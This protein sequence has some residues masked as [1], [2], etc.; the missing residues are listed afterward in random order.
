MKHL[1]AVVFG[2]STIVAGSSIASAA[3]YI[4]HVHGRSQQ[5]WKSDPNGARMVLAD[6]SGT[7]WIN[8]TLAFN[9]NARLTSTETDSTTNT[10]SVNY[11]IRTFC[12]TGTGNTC[13]V[14]CYSTG[15][16]R[17]D[18]AIDNIRNGVGGTAN[19]LSGLLYI[20]ASASASGG[21]D[22]A[23]IAT[24]KFTGWLAK[25]LGQQEAVDK[26][27]TRSAARTTFSYV[28]D[29]LGVNKWHVAG[30]GD[31]CKKLLGLF[32]ICG[33]SSIAGTDDGVLP[34]A[35]SGG[36]SAQTSRTSL[37]NL[38][39]AD[40]QDTSKNVAN[41]YPWHRTDTYYVNC[42][43]TSV[44]DGG[45]WDHFGIADFG[46]A[47]VEADIRNGSAL[48]AHWAWGDAASETSC[49]SSSSCDN[50]FFNTNN[51][52][53]GTKYADGY[54]TGATGV[55]SWTSQT[56]GAT[57]STTSCAGRCGTA[58]AGY[59]GCTTGATNKC[60]DYLTVN[61]DDVNL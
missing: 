5:G 40:E 25:L 31:V 26:D 29:Q 57:G 34:W 6:T 60:S 24:G 12:G 45:T 10:N 2:L 43:G 59:C 56:W 13:I 53:F 17:V 50:A 42:N 38:S 46:E 55:D 32:K 44:A 9:G 51:N 28:H 21:T 20:Q 23:E 19:T 39:A 35:S 11:A 54:N 49:S 48:Y 30:Y 36:Y 15:C 16:L 18:K 4:L 14:H 7:T 58:P 41:K 61:C 22:L 27:L 33:S 47:I 8:R 52:D 1:L 37:C 3:N